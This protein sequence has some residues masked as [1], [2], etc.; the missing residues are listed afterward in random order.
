MQ[1]RSRDALIICLEASGMSERQLAR[2][3]GLGHATVNHLVTGRR[4]RCSPATAGAIEKA[5]GCEVGTLFDGSPPTDPQ[6][7]RFSAQPAAHPPAR[8]E[9]RHQPELNQ[10]L[11]FDPEKLAAMRGVQ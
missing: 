5:L 6:W 8:A 7:H 11:A 4:T 1:L 3:A 9:L 2:V 10:R